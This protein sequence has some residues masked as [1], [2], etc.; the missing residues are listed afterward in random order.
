MLRRNVR[1]RKEF[2][3]KK[4]LEDKEAVT[5]ENKRKLKEALDNNKA[6]A[7]ELR[8]QENKLRKTL[9]LADERTEAQRTHEDDEYAYVGCKDPKV[10][11]TTSRD[12]SSRLRQFVKEMT[13]IVPGSQRLNRGNYV[14]TDLMDMA[15]KHDVTD[16]VVVHEH[17]G[18]PDGMIVS[19]LPHGPT[20]YFGL[21]DVILRHDLPDRPPKVS[22]ARPHLIFHEFDTKLGRRV[23]SILQALFPVA[24]PLCKRA[25]TF[26]N[27]NDS[28]HFRHHVWSSESTHGED[29]DPSA[30]KKEEL[31]LLECGP[32]FTMNIYRI[33]LGTLD[34]KDVT[35]EW[36]LRPH[37]N[38]QRTALATSN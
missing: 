36:V 3:F 16:V 23:K 13:L 17:R 27:V 38:K 5:F 28:I 22:E 6:I 2:L 34:M 26:A 18:K 11:I 24:A 19:H 14:M 37:F 29:E 9:D 32:R 4:A 8:G 10:L 20:A 7:P 35:T 25:M 21:R 33:E 31:A 1:Q 30:K 12:A 15:R